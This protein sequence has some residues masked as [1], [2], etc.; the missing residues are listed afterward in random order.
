LLS[1]VIPMVNE[2][3]VLPALLGRLQALRSADCEVIVVDGQSTDNS[4]ELVR[5][6][7]FSVISSRRGRAWQLNTG[8]AHSRGEQLLFLHADTVLPPQALPLIQQSLQA[9]ISWGRFDVQID[10]QHPMLRVVAWAM[11]LRSRLTG[12]ATGDQAQFMSRQAFEQAGG[13]PEQALMEDIE[14]SRRLLTLA[15]PHCLRA[16]VLTSGRRWET[17]GVWRTIRL[18]WRLRWDYWRGVP[19]AQLAARYQ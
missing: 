2:A 1:I 14:L 4:V 18:M 9:P 8:A 13:Y 15:A 12:I 3:A 19:V 5:Q 7:G 11:N 6:A 16:K 10:G 17:R